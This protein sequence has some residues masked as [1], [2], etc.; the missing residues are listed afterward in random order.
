MISAEFAGE[1]PTEEG[2]KLAENG[3]SEG[4]RN[5]SGT[6]RAGEDAGTVEGGTIQPA[7]EKEREATHSEASSGGEVLELEAATALHR[8]IAAAL[9]RGDIVAAGRAAKALSALLGV[10]GEVV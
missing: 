6:I 7:T 8:T 2:P 3:S 1:G 4:A 9:G 10:I 5:N